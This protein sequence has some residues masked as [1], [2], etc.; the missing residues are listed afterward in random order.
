ML[1]TTKNINYTID[2][3]MSGVSNNLFYN[4]FREALMGNSEGKHH[5]KDAKDNQTGSN[6]PETT[7][8]Q[9]DGKEQG[10]RTL[11]IFT[12]RMLV[13]RNLTI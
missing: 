9:V 1:R 3:V 11:I 12:E 4:K 6:K 2:P 8:T 10:L 5:P 13:W 7:N